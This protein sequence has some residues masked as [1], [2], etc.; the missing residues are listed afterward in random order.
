ML[1]AGVSFSERPAS[2]VAFA[3]ATLTCRYYRNVTTEVEVAWLR[4][5]PQY[6]PQLSR[7]QR[8]IGWRSLIEALGG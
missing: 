7:R 5:N 3:V 8:M 1:L 6:L 2:Q 4:L